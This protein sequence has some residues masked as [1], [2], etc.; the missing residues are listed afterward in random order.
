MTDSV[1]NRTFR[2]ARRCRR[3][4]SAAV[5]C[6]SF[7]TSGSG[8]TMVTSCPFSARC[9]AVPPP[10]QL[11]PSSSTV[12]RC[13][14]RAALPITSSTDH[15]ERGSYPASLSTWGRAFWNPDSAG[16]D[17]VAVMTV[18]AP[19][20]ITSPASMGAL[21][22]ISTPS[23]SSCPAYQ[24]IRSRI[25]ARRGCSPAS[26]N[27]PPSRSDASA[28]TTLCPRSAATRAA[29]RPAGPAPIT[30]TD[31]GV[32]ALVNRS[33]PHSNSLPADGLTR[34]EIQ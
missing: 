7:P 28:R 16:S 10:R 30:A 27:C 8:V 31:P 6:S 3:G 22:M 17:P 11:P 4:K 1:T 9:Q 15:T 26:R 24:S 23:L 13:P 18:S 19:R 32:S 34:Q 14:S 33:P 2:A 21:Y 5:R 25:W 29:S 12:T 20:E